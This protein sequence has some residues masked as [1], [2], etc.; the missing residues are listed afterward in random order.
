MFCD[1]FFYYQK[2]V[3]VGHNHKIELQYGTFMFVK[4]IFLSLTMV[5]VVSFMR[6]CLTR[7]LDL[8]S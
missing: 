7:C 5:L 2:R 4:L 3:N 6:L 8:D 1:A